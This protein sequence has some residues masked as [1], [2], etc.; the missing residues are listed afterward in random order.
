MWWPFDNGAIHW[1]D[2]PAPP[3]LPYMLGPNTSGAVAVALSALS[4][5]PMPAVPLAMASAGPM[6]GSAPPHLHMSTPE[7]L[8]PFTF[9]SAFTAVPASLRGSGDTGGQAT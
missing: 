5:D 3:A 2:R 9:V 6:T 4:A 8:T 1:P 7:G